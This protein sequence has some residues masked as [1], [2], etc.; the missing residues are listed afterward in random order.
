VR[1]S[2][3]LPPLSFFQEQYLTLG[4]GGSS[5]SIL[6]DYRL[7][8]RGSIPSSVCVQTSSE[9]HPASCLMGSDDYFSGGKARPGRELTSHP[10][11]V[12]RSRLS[13]SYIT[14]SPWRLLGSAGSLYFT[15]HLTLPPLNIFQSQRLKGR[16]AVQIFLFGRS[17]SANPN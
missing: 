11:V 8:D 2:S 13:T 17:V 6:S 7:D 14:S 5:V 16:A 3:L 12:P 1:G 9:A 15:L 10:H 4:V